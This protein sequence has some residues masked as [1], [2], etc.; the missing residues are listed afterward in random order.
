MFQSG[1]QTVPIWIDVVRT[2]HQPQLHNDSQGGTYLGRELQS[3]DDWDMPLAMGCALWSFGRKDLAAKMNSIGYI[4]PTQA[5]VGGL[6]RCL[7]T[8]Y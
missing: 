1:Q 2:P 4:L 3:A 5:M 6:W 7:E 8:C